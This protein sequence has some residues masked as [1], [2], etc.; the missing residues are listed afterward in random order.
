MI[1]ILE[2]LAESDDEELYAA[3]GAQ[4]LGQGLGAGVVDDDQHRRFGMRW[5]EERIDRF[6]EAVCDT[7]IVAGL[8]GDFTADVTAVA[9]ALPLG[10]DRILALTIAAIILRRGLTEFCR[11]RDSA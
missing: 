1:D 9:S 4:L 3:L 11:T 6:R 8:T 2:L 5:F 7:Q 10:D